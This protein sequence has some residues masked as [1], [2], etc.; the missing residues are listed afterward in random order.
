MLWRFGRSLLVA[1]YTFLVA[2]L[3]LFSLFEPTFK[4]SG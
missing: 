4:E 3:L 1:A 2:S